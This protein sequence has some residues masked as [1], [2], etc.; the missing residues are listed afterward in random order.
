MKI[1]L[2]EAYGPEIKFDR[3]SLI[4]ALTPQAC[5]QLD[6]A[7]IE[8]SIVE[9]YYNLLELSAREDDYH[10]AQLR[11]IA[12]LDSF[13]QE[14]V[15]ELKELG[16]KPGYIYYFYLITAILDP[17]YLRCYA[18][19]K[20]F[21]AVRPTS[22][23]FISPQTVEVPLSS[24]LYNNGRSYYSKITEVICRESEITM[25]SVF[26]EPD[27]KN[28][29]NAVGRYEG[30]PAR[31]RRLLAGSSQV[32][33][34]FFFPRRLFFVYKCLK[35]RFFPSQISP[36]PLNIL[37]LKLTHTGEGFIIEAL[38][39]GHNVY[40]LVDKA[41]ARCTCY[42]TRKEYNLK[43]ETARPK[44][45]DD[46][47][48]EKTA[49]GL[50][51]HELINQINEL[52]QCDVSGIILP[53]LKY[54]V[55][56]VCPE[57][58]N[59]YRMFSDFYQK[60]KVD[61]VIT[62][63]E[64]KTAEFAAIAAAGRYHSTRSVDLQH[65][66]SA[67]AANFWDII[68]LSRFD[69]DITSNEEF[70]E[71]FERRCQLKN[72]TANIYRSPHRLLPVK[73]LGLRRETGKSVKKNRIVYLPTF[74]VGEHARFDRAYYPDTWYYQFQRALIE[75]FSTRQEFTFVWK[76]LPTSDVLY[77][78]IPDFIKANNYKN[79]K[80]A[81]DPFT[82]HLL[83]A[84]RVILDYPST[85]FYESVVAGISTLS[86][87]HRTLRLRQSA[88]DFFGNLMAPFTETAE[89]IGH[90]EKFL[91]SDPELYK[92]NINMQGSGILD[93]LEE[94]GREEAE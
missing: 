34:A 4:I 74:F 23:T 73:R 69:I 8:Y 83:T 1:Y 87:Y 91:E 49:G 64:I 60:A 85:G 72:F 66:D 92:A 57:I 11:W 93:I 28:A 56:R 29:G 30:F 89:A 50:E 53:G 12:G 75:Y 81:T 94:I 16:L 70:R 80:I 24:N 32:R 90:I 2:L 68:F 38:K 18:L 78:P 62:P 55:S 44:V 17:V 76:G 20:V 54:F 84:D 21:A 42:G 14:N 22:L 37:L 46:N 41:I 7:G 63:H 51:G 35:N 13:L 45:P 67:L 77:N 6:K 27:S 43:A 65:G 15:K 3:D 31:I 79:I 5:Y 88:V 10:Q 39:R 40:Q 26:L 82:R 19:Q 52:C 36:A 58:V 86:L 9:D 59:N 61:F 48:W 47:V 71:Y 25:E 33:K